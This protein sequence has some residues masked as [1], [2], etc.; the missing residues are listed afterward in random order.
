MAYIKE[1]VISES[2]HCFQ[3]SLY[4]SNRKQVNSE[5]VYPKI[6]G[7][8]SLLKTSFP[9]TFPNL[10]ASSLYNF[11]YYFESQLMSNWLLICV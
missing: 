11:S 4:K 8:V 6:S 5:G 1:S 7:H 9:V 3:F 10:V 2:G